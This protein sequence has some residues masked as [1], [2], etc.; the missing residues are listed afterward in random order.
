ML[1]G[2]SHF[3]LGRLADAETHLLASVAAYDR[4]QHGAH[5]YRFGQDPEI[6]A[7][8][9]LSWVFFCRGDE[10]RRVAN[11]R[12]TLE[13]A[14]SLGHPNSLGFAL[15][16]AGWS[17][18]FADDLRGLE[19][20]TRELGALSGEYGLSSFV[21]QAKVLAALRQG[22]SEGAAGALAALERGV[23]AWRS[24]GSRCFQICWD[25]QLARA[26]LAA[27]QPARAAEI[28]GRAEAALEAT[29]ERWS[30][31][32]LHRCR[33]QVESAQGRREAALACLDRAREVAARS[34][35][36]GWYIGAACD[37]AELLGAADAVEA[38]AVLED[39]IGRLPSPAAGSWLE[40]ARSL[41]ATLAAH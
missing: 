39:A 38:R 2:L 41:D 17:R 28:L 37:T 19:D 7:S 40:R 22:R 33:A 23:D 12:R 21:V 26:C 15:A 5:A 4:A 34:G 16:W 27:G 18:V 25:V 24:I 9:Y 20:I 31:S 3:F 30:E 1:L 32:D 10:V 14:R 35:A 13:R 11:E 29:D 6:V 36:W 8:S